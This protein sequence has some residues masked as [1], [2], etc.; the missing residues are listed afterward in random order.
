IDNH[1]PTGVSAGGPYHITEGND[2]TLSAAA[3][4]PDGDT[5]SFSWDING[6]G[7]YGDAIGA[8]PTLTWAQL[9]APGVT[10]GPG[11]AARA[12]VAVSDGDGHTVTSAVVTLAYAGP[13]VVVASFFDSAVYEMDAVTGSVVQTLV[14]ANSQA[15]LLGPAGMTVGPDGNLYL[16]S[17][18]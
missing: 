11:S 3:T 12:R 18:F 7:I 1:A 4:D 14:T 5:L 2:L 15:T 8:N 6:D 16:S 10:A 17:Q 13:P 9:T